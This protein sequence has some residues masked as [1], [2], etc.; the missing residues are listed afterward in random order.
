MLSPDGRTLC[1]ADA[2]SIRL[3]DV[4]AGTPLASKQL[5]GHVA[6]GDYVGDGS[7]IALFIDHGDEKTLVLHTAD[8]AHERRVPLGKK[9]HEA[10][11]SP[12]GR[13]IAIAPSLSSDERGA[14]VIR[15]VDAEA[16]LTSIPVSEWS[17]AQ[18]AFSPTGDR[19]AYTDRGLRIRELATG[20]ELVI[21]SLQSNTMKVV[22][23]PD[24]RRV[25]TVGSG[26]VEV[27]DAATG[28]RLL[29]RKESSYTI[30]SPSFSA[31]GSQIVYGVESTV[32]LLDVATGEPAGRHEPP[33]IGLRTA[34]LSPDGSRVVTSSA[35]AI[36]VWDAATG[37]RLRTFPVTGTPYHLT[38][39]PDGRRVAFHLDGR[40]QLLAL[41]GKGRPSWKSRHISHCDSL[42]VS[43]DGA[44]FAAGAEIKNQ[45][46]VVVWSAKTR[47]RRYEFTGHKAPIEALAFTPDGQTLVSGSAS[48]F[49]HGDTYG[50]RSV[51]QLFST[52][53]GTLQATYKIGEKIERVAL[54]GGADLLI[55]SGGWSSQRRIGKKFHRLSSALVAV[56]PDGRT[57]A[58][59]APGGYRIEGPG[60]LASL[61]SSDRLVSISN[62]G[63]RLLTR[64]AVD[65]CLVWSSEGHG[66][67]R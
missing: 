27:W 60:G 28:E 9:V 8:L 6:R 16:P 23:S 57:I 63:H 25:A 34:A 36:T 51:V 11:V 18:L 42:A 37:E 58:S 15:A 65:T 39:F 33:L 22:F 26:H 32:R 20:A 3:L 7:H 53:T 5:T 55:V 61:A 46:T 13:R 48:S 17:R 54:H 29:V 10:V 64:D 38:F 43:P 45:H 2:S 30:G 62:R 31:D 19:L 41:D 52:R 12:D 14:I 56:S 21:E 35:G 40:V 4:A 59:T 67:T 47:K 50:N 66:A 44:W 49:K 1:V 24:G